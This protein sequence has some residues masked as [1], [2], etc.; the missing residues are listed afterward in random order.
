MFIDIGGFI[1]SI[2]WMWSWEKWS[3]IYNLMDCRLWRSL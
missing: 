1:L 3:V 2:T